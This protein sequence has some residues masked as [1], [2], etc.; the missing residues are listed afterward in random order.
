L[1]KISLDD[2]L[3]AKLYTVLP[4]VREVSVEIQATK[5]IRTS[6]KNLR[7]DL[8]AAI[9]ADAEAY[10][11]LVGLTV[12]PHAVDKPID[13]LIDANYISNDN[14]WLGT[15]AHE[16]THAGHYYQL[17]MKES[18]DCYDPLILVTQW[19]KH[20]LFQMWSEFHARKN[21]DTFIQ[22]LLK[23]GGTAPVLNADW[24][25]D[26]E[27]YQKEYATSNTLHKICI[28]E[29]MLFLGSI[30]ARC[31]FFPEIL[32]SD[33]LKKLFSANPRLKR[34]LTFSQQYDTLET[35]YPRLD[36]LKQIFFQIE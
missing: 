18:L 13:V 35:V 11:N 23:E 34:V 4:D 1:L 15:I 24:Q 29:M 2:A 22:C 33:T 28:Y 16:L 19:S 31:D 12:L 17:A 27:E 26:I 8:V 3:L 6:Y 5:C 10:D 20:W 9:E 14:A 25:S 32:D 30:S 21:G 36:E 7:P